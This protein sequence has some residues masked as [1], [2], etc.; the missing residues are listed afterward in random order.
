M[1]ERTVRNNKQKFIIRLSYVRNGEQQPTRKTKLKNKQTNAN[2]RNPSTAVKIAYR[3]GRKF[4]FAVIIV[5]GPMGERRVGGIYI[6]G[7]M[8]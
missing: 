2:K 5:D 1:S 8:V 3:I 6:I 4:T 7:T